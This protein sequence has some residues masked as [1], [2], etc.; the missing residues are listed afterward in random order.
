MASGHSVARRA[1]IYENSQLWCTTRIIF[2]LGFEFMFTA[3]EFSLWELKSI[4]ARTD[5]WKPT[6]FSLMFDAILGKVMRVNNI[7]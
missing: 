2:I 7:L 4:F 1:L 5:T 3:G 6:I